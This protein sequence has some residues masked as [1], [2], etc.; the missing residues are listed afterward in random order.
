MRY[1]HLG[2]PTGR[3]MPGEIY[4]EHLGLH[5]TDHR[6][7]P[8]GIQ[9]MR[10]DPDCR[11]PELVMTVPHVAFEVEDLEE[12][13]EGMEVII[14]PNSPAAGVRVAFVVSHGAPV[15]LLEVGGPGSYGEEDREQ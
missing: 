7:N 1:H 6:S 5:C 9:W 12:A 10:F 11:L 8:F 2:I 13:L 15:E 14:E 4:I 3:V